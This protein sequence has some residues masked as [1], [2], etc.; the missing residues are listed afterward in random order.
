MDLLSGLLLL[1][2]L[3]FFFAFFSGFLVRLLNDERRLWTTDQI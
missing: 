2:V 1:L 3:R